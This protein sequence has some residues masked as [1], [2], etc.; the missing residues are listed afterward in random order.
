MNR[1]I[2]VTGMRQPVSQWRYD[3]DD[4]NR[5]AT[6]KLSA[7]L[8]PCAAKGALCNVR[9]SSIRRS[10]RGSDIVTTVTADKNDATI[11]LRSKAARAALGQAA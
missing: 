6:D 10:L 8:S 2:D 7:N 4:R 9:A 11:L 5:Q 1:Y 3:V